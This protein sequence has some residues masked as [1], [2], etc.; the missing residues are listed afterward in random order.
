MR[1][2]KP[3]L[4][5]N[6]HVL[7][8]TCESRER[9][10]LLSQP[11]ENKYSEKLVLLESQALPAVPRRRNLG[12]VWAR[13]VLGQAAG[14]RQHTWTTQRRFPRE[15]GPLLPG[16]EGKAKHSRKTKNTA[17]AVHLQV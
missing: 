10:T 2:R 4:Q 1:E 7:L 17:P 15:R 14:P 13:P 3:F 8:L 16:E 11:P 12:T 9:E 6:A 5:Q